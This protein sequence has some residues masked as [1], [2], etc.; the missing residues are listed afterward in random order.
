MSITFLGTLWKGF[1][2]K[3]LMFKWLV[4]KYFDAKGIVIGVLKIIK[5]EYGQ[6]WVNMDTF[7]YRLWLSLMKR[8]YDFPIQREI[9]PLKWAT[10]EYGNMLFYRNIYRHGTEQ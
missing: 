10:T 5:V 9:I 3:I 1:P 8:R 2:Y 7:T 4:S 6:S